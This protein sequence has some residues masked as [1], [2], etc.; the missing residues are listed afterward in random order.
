MTMSTSAGWQDA[1]S[2]YQ[3]LPC[4]APP[5]LLMFPGSYARVLRLLHESLGIRLPPLHLSYCLFS[6]LLSDHESQATTSLGTLP[7]SG[8]FS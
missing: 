5:L 1:V 8:D 3:F 6:P 4:S 7:S 2:R